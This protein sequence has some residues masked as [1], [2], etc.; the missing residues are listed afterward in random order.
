MLP[1]KRFIFLLTGYLGIPLLIAAQGVPANLP[2]E[3]SLEQCIEYAI[4]NQP[5]VRQALLNES[6]GEQEIKAN[7]AGF[8]RF[9]HSITCSIS[10]NC[11]PPSYQILRI[12]LRAGG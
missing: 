9:P 3:L 12:F 7:L 6:I 8:L 11:L 4:K 1:I 10:S 2:G 5:G